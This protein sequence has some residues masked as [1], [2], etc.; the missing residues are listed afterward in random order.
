VL[1]LLLLLL[2]LF[3]SERWYQLI[4]FRNG[5]KWVRHLF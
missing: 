4:G 1:L 3:Y 5:H 2:L